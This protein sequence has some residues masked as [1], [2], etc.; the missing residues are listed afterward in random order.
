[1]Y[2]RQAISS[3]TLTIDLSLGQL[4]LVS[5]NSNITTLSIT[6]VPSST[7]AVGFSIIFTAD[8]TARSVTWPTSVKW[9]SA[10]PPTLTST[11]TK[12]DVLSFVSTDNGTSWL[13]FVGGQNF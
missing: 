4:F 5:L 8:G 6:N 10:S 11:S 2:K 9:P 12:K 3:S 1:M 13:G 7:N